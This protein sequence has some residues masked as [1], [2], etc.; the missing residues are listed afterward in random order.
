MRYARLQVRAVRSLYMLE[1]DYPG[2]VRWEGNLGF[3]GEVWGVS[4]DESALGE[5]G[6]AA[7][8]IAWQVSCSLLFLFFLGSSLTPRTRR[9]CRRVSACGSRTNINH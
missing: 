5:G 1:L 9:A 8:D 6:E 2:A 4:E 3:D 7:V